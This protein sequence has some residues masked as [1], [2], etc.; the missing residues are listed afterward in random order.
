MTTW[1]DERVDLAKMLWSDG[2]SASQIAGRLGGVTRNAVIGKV[3]R[4]GLSGRATRKHGVGPK[5]L[6]NSKRKANERILTEKLLAERAA[7]KALAE[8]R[9]L[10]QVGPDIDIPAGER[11]SLIDLEP[12]DCRWAYGDG[13]FSF[14]NRLQVGTERRAHKGALPYCDFHSKR[15]YSASIPRDR[16]SDLD[17]ARRESDRKLRY[18]AMHH[19]LGSPRLS[20][21]NVDDVVPR[22][23]EPAGDV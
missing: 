5:R 12:G 18:A 17:L 21:P 15:A 9:R 19:G 4:L 11:R 8:E 16:L 2:L 13:P 10:S 20:T 3:H 6:Q 23:L 14:C 22:V 1:T 7:L